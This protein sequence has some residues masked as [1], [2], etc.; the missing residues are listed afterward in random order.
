MIIYFGN[1]NIKKV[2]SSEIQLT[3]NAGSS[4]NRR[5]N[6]MVIL[7]LAYFGNKTLSITCTTPFV[8]EI[9]AFVTLLSLIFTPFDKSTLIF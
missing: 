6:V 2:Y 5:F 8:P 4:T 3:I 7:I 9:S 1:L